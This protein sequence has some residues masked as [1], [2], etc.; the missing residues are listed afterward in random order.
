MPEPDPSYRKLVEG[1]V[2]FLVGLCFVIT[3][4]LILIA[5]YGLMTRFASWAANS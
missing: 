1:G 4:G 2:K 5:A 3:M